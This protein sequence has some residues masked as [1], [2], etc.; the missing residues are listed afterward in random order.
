MKDII[1]SK[2]ALAD[3][4]NVLT[5]SPTATVFECIGRMVDRDVG[6]IVVMEGDAIA[7]LFTER[8]Y[9]QGIALKG[10]SSDETEVQAVMTEDVATV[11]PDKPL[12][13][14][15]RLMTRLRCRHLPVVDEGGDLIGIVSIGDGV[16][17]IIQTA[18]RETSRLRQ[19]V[20]GTYAE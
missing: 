3:D 17:Q 16:K 7:G 14:C 2:S 12:E 19:Y 4:G 5:T 18:Q 1:Q 9:M 6:S 13:E 11:R 15:L 8:N 10:R 20:T